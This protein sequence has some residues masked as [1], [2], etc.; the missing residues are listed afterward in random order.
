VLGTGYFN[1][2][3][4]QQDWVRA[5]A[6]MTR[7][8]ASG[9]AAAQ[10]NLAQMDQYIPL[11]Q[12]QEATALAA[13]MEQDEI[14]NRTLQTAGLRAPPSTN[15]VESA[16]L[17]PSQAAASAPIPAPAPAATASG[18]TRPGVSFTLPEA[19]STPPS[20]ARAQTPPPAVAP[21]PAAPPVQTARVPAPAQTAVAAPAPRGGNWRIQL[22]AFGQADRAKSL[23]TRLEGQVAGLSDLQPYLVN[24]GAVTRLQA[25]PFASRA[26]AEQMCRAVIASGN[27]C[28]AKAQ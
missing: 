22:G 19:T 7:A 1:G 10:R 20:P 16:E 25:G 17:P 28:I 21:R 5:Y 12:R 2:D 6:L 13:Q 26:E 14:R 8:S 24:A 15:A 27:S 9:L 4:V 23:W 11:S 3:F 18:P